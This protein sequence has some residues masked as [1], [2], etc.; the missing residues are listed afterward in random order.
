MSFGMQ[1]TN[2][3]FLRPIRFSTPSSCPALSPSALEEKSDEM[4]SIL[5]DVYSRDETLPS[6]LVIIPGKKAWS[7]AVD[8]M[9]LSEDGNL[10]D[11]LFMAVHA[12]LYNCRVPATRSIQY[13]AQASIGTESGLD[14]RPGTNPTADFEL[15]DNW[16]DGEMLLNHKS[17]PVSI[18]LNL[19]TSL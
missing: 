13:K 11:V 7:L 10:L 4:T 3:S 18:T 5:S 14:T 16:E 2:D 1:S 8:A 12:A 6:N 17:L 15:K 19:V 9:V